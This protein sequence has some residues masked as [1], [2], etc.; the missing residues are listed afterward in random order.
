MVI[1]MVI[2]RAVLTTDFGRLRLVRRQLLNK[3]TTEM[4][5]TSAE[6]IYAKDLA[7]WSR[8]VCGNVGVVMCTL[9]WLRR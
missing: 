1:L 7:D 5:F 9:P 3:P 4:S 6:E 8:L 2:L